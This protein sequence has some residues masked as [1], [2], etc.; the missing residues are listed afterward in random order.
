MT[1]KYA[2]V[3]SSLSYNTRNHNNI[4]LPLPR[5]TF[6][7]QSLKYDSLKIFIELPEHFK[8]SIS[9]KILRSERTFNVQS[10][11]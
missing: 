10:I 4:R 5:F 9:D 6:A 11:L 3:T 2:G 8:I 1:I 7:K